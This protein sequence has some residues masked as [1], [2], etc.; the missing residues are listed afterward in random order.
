MKENTEALVDQG[1][2]MVEATTKVLEEASKERMELVSQHYQEVERSKMV[3]DRVQTTY[4]TKLMEYEVQATTTTNLIKQLKKEKEAM[5]DKVK[6]G[7]KR[8]WIIIRAWR[9]QIKI[10]IDDCSTVVWN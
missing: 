4:Q 1:R 10:K 3:L 5:E 6:M 7:I 9:D 2:M 8:I